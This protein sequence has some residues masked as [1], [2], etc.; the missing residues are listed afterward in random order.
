MTAEHLP[1]K[2]DNSAARAGIPLSPGTKEVRLKTRRLGSKQRLGSDVTARL[3]CVL[4]QCNFTA[5]QSK[6]AKE[7]IVR[8]K[9]YLMAWEE[10]GVKPNDREVQWAEAKSSIKGADHPETKEALKEADRIIDV[11]RAQKQTTKP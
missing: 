5:K 10:D 1:T 8:L 2:P 9:V 11:I 6:P 4:G 3:L 7:E